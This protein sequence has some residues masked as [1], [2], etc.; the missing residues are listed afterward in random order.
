MTRTDIHRPSAPEFDP[1][2]YNCYGVFDN[3]PEW[4]GSRERLEAVNALRAQGFKV[5]HGSSRSCG[6]C[7]SRIRYAALMVREDVKQFIFVGEDCLEGR[8]EMEKAEF[9]ELREQGR[10]NKEQATKAQRITEAVEAEPMLA[11]LTYPAFTNESNDFIADVAERFRREG[12]LSDNQIA[13][14]KS[15]LVKDT[16]RRLAAQEREIV[17]A[18][19][20]EQGVEAPTGKQLVEGEVVTLKTQESM[21]GTTY[22]MVVKTAA[23]WAVWVT[24]P[25]AISEVK[26]GQQVRFT[27]TLERSD[28]DPLFAFGKRPTKAE[29][30]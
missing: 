23:G 8:F 7:G 18:A 16:E 28:R 22:K 30:L 13:A 21:Y 15:A 3:D 17:K 6:H 9:S 27:A 29:I 24:V 2:A 4:G 12:R 26:K 5:G 1:M 14:V 19:L 10:L 11:W 20:L 25:V